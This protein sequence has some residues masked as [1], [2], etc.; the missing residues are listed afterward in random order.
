MIRVC[1]KQNI[2]EVQERKKK[3]QKTRST[4]KQHGHRERSTNQ[5]YYQYVCIV[6][7]TDTTVIVQD[8]ITSTEMWRGCSYH[9]S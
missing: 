3:K 6:Y 1:N 2:F 7:E 4:R 5:I 9:E 8:E